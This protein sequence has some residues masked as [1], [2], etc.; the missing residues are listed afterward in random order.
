MEQHEQFGGH[1]HDHK[2]EGSG[3]ELYPRPVHLD[4]RRAARHPHFRHAQVELIIQPVHA[5]AH[6]LM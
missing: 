4:G 1:T 6:G 3:N 5:R 2:T